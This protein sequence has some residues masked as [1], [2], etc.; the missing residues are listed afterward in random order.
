MVKDIILNIAEY[1]EEK[2]FHYVKVVINNQHTIKRRCLNYMLD[3]KKK[4]EWSFGLGFI[5]L[6]QI[7]ILSM[8][9]IFHDNIEFI[10]SLQNS[11]D[12]D[13]LYLIFF[14]LFIAYAFQYIYKDI[15]GL[16][17]KYAR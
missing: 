15:K 11:L 2:T 6:Y 5:F 4:K 16:I 14:I 3:E 7:I 17:K 8:Y 9:W 12:Y 10:S 13:K 1:V